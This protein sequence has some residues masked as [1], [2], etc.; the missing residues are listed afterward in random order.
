MKKTFLLLIASI[1]VM[2]QPK[3][4]SASMT[5]QKL[6]ENLIGRIHTINS[7]ID[8][9]KRD[10]HNEYLEYNGQMLYTDINTQKSTFSE[11]S[12]KND[13]LRTCIEEINNEIEQL[14]INDSSI[15]KIRAYYENSIVDSL[16]AH[17]DPSSLKVHK[18]ILGSDYPKVMDDLQVLLE[19]AEMLKKVYE[20]SQNS[21]LLQKLKIIQPCKNQ[22]YL[23]GLLSVQK[24]ITDEVNSWIMNEEHTLY[25]MVLFRTYLYNN[26][27]ISLHEDFPYLANMV[28]E[29]V[30]IAI[31]PK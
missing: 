3:Q 1:I 17:V 30:R 28:I 10:I 13:S 18:R 14:K 12:K 31:I 16:F 2:H 8:S 4:M 29:K 5:S 15:D 19:S 20:A 9:L 24:E 11:I 7:Q 25:N 6:S 23:D 21:A 22:E 27:G 26:Y